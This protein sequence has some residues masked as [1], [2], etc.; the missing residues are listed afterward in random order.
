MIG[1]Q[2]DSLLKSSFTK[3]ILKTEIFTSNVQEGKMEKNQNQ[4]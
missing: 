3:F 2:E 4:I 1:F